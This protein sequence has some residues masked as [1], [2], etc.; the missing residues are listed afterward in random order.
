M[1]PL[2]KNNEKSGNKKF[3]CYLTLDQLHQQKCNNNVKVIKRE[4]KKN[5]TICYYSSQKKATKI[6]FRN[7]L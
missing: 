6:S 5:E 3:C 4:R 1:H 7:L 2:K